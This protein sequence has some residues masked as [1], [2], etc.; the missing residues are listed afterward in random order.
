MFTQQQAESY[1]KRLL[2][3]DVKGAICDRQIKRKM[4]KMS[5]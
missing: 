1:K 5:L 4:F 2:E 3:S